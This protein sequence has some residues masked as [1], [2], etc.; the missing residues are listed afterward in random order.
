MAWKAILTLVLYSLWAAF[1]LS[2]M[3][4]SRRKVSL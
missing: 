2:K 4:Y 1:K 3:W